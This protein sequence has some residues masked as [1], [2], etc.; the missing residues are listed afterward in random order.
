MEKIRISSLEI[1]ELLKVCAPC[2]PDELSAASLEVMAINIFFCFSFFLL[3]KILLRIHYIHL[4]VVFITADA[5]MC[6]E[7]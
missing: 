1:L 5:E 2:L 4:Y 3:K 6:T 7:N